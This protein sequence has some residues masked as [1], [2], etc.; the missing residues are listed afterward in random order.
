MPASS[1][2]VLLE[3]P[4]EGDF[5][6]TPEME[7]AASQTPLM[8]ACRVPGRTSQIFFQKFFGF[9][10]RN[11]KTYFKKFSVAAMF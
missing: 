1:K 10:R 9:L 6:V 2:Q 5:F 11:F 7:S 8:E 4:I 3:R